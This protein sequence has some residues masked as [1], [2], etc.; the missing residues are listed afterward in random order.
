[1]LIVCRLFELF[2]VFAR[3]IRCCQGEDHW[4]VWLSFSVYASYLAL[5]IDHLSTTSW[6]NLCKLNELV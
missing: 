3:D 1:M 6:L 5:I 2:S 4:V